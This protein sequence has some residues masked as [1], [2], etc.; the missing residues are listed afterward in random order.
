MPT[1]DEKSLAQGELSV[2]VDQDQEHEQER[3]RCSYCLE[4]WIFLGS[5]GYDGEEV[6]ESIRCRRCGGK[7]QIA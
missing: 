1:V 3:R 7:G 2:R 5:L 6:I 4:G